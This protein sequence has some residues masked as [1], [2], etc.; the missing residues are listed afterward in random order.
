MHQKDLS[1]SVNDLQKLAILDAQ[2][3]VN[4]INQ[5]CFGM[6]AVSLDDFFL[7]LFSGVGINK[8]LYTL[9]EEGMNEV[10]LIN[11]TTSFIQQLFT[12]NTYLKLYGQLNIREIWG[13]NLP[14]HIADSRAK[15][16]IRYTQD[17]FLE[18]LNTFQNLELE[19]KTKSTL[20]VNSYTQACF[21]KFSD[22]LR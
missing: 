16:A 13:Y 19:L 12:I 14:S 20:D 7:K 6:G 3:S 4:I 1:L 9:L 2:I 10:Q 21:R 15:V 11:Q 17:Q 22:S 8:D 18:M 5:Q